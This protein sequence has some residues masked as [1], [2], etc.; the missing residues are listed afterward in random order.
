[1]YFKQFCLVLTLTSIF[2][3]FYYKVLIMK[4]VS[5]VNIDTVRFPVVLS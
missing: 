5:K 1:M 3:I 4:S 2:S